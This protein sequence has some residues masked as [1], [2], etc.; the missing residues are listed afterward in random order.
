MGKPNRA[1]MPL[2]RNDRNVEIAIVYHW[3]DSKYIVTVARVSENGGG[4]L[5]MT[6][7]QGREL[8]AVIDK[9][10]QTAGCTFDDWDRLFSDALIA[11]K[12]EFEKSGGTGSGKTDDVD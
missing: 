5:V 10:R 11:A 3:Q 1:S 4:E 9:S 2:T 12:D 6:V 7:E 8:D